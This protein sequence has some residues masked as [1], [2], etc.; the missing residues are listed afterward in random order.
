M[1]LFHG[2]VE[3]QNGQR[4]LELRDRRT[5]RQRSSPMSPSHRVL[6]LTLTVQNPRDMSG[7]TYVSPWGDSTVI[8]P[9]AQK[10]L[11]RAGEGLGQGLAPSL[12]LDGMGGTYVLRDAKRRPV[13]AFKPRDE[14]PFAP[15]NPRGLAGKMGQPGIH[16]AIPSGES[17][18]REVLAYRLDHG[19]FASVPPT[20]QAEA[21]HP[22]FNVQSIQALSRY[23]AKVGSLQA[24]VGDSELAADMG[25]SSFP[26]AEVHKLAILDLRMLNTDRNDGNILV[27]RSA[28][29]TVRRQRRRWSR[30]EGEEG[31]NDGEP[32]RDNSAREPDDA[33]DEGSDGVDRRRGVFLVPIDHGG[34]LPTMP[35]VA[36]YN[37]CWLSWP[38]MSAPLA[39]EMLEY[40]RNLDG[41]EDG[42][43]IVDAGLPPACARICRC[44]T[45]ALQRG[46]AS[47]LTLLQV[48]TML[49]RADEETP[50]ELERLWGQAERLA[51]S[52][53]RNH[54]LR[55]P[56]APSLPATCAATH[57]GSTGGPMPR[58]LERVMSAQDD[59]TT[60]GGTAVDASAIAISSI[61]RTSSCGDELQDACSSS[62]RG[63]PR[64]PPWFAAKLPP[65]SLH[66]ERERT[67]SAESSSASSSQYVGSPAEGVGELPSP[68]RPPR[69]A[70][71]PLPVAAVGLHRRVASFST[72]ES[73]DTTPAGEAGL[74]RGAHRRPVLAPLPVG[75][76]EVAEWDAEAALDALFYTYFARLLDEYIKRIIGLQRRQEREQ[77][78]QQQQQQKQG[79]EN[80]ARTQADA[81][82]P[83]PRRRSPSSDANQPPPPPASP[84]R[85]GTPPLTH[86]APAAGTP[87]KTAKGFVVPIGS[88]PLAAASIVVT[89]PSPRSPL[90]SERRRA[91]ESRG[92]AEEVRG[93]MQRERGSSSRSRSEESEGLFGPHAEEVGGDVGGFMWSECHTSE[94]I[95][96]SR[97]SHDGGRMNAFA[98]DGM[99]PM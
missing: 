73:L 40:I 56:V 84:Q 70:P 90:A 62:N 10:L 30:H 50:S 35:E 77:Q 95:C 38:Q 98:A 68:P 64:A 7:G 23:G 17:H 74:T 16:P 80:E 78:Q 65:L 85:A 82:L 55:G 88:A 14:E 25:Y 86:D 24:W 92:R 33:S 29:T 48:A 67:D 76:E 54:R 89:P 53:V 15:N 83:P 43:A 20:V 27:T 8:D 3:L 57:D 31:K 18:L 21:L 66:E 87:G 81:P 61:R 69:Q 47:G 42:R 5:A 99:A 34:I 46:V 1:R 28:P 79:D 11:A 45:L 36:W 51:H 32:R 93:P 19:G 6:K 63:E 44:T 58:R 22:A 39:P 41:I 94:E 60:A 37:W 59:V 49:S 13:A 96:M 9:L 4:L 52:A 71:S 97:D 75:A 91:E 26:A 2:P 72:L 12:A